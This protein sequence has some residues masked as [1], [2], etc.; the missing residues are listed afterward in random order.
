MK[1][2]AGNHEYR[3]RR[4][5]EPRSL[6]EAQETIRGAARIR[7]LGSRHSFND[8]ADTS[9]A[10]ITLAGLPRFL[11]IDPETSSVTVDGAIRY[12]ELCPALHEAGFAL[13]AMASLPHISIAG[14][15]ATASHGSGDR[16]SV[17]SAAVSAME[18]VRA[19]GEVVEL[20]REGDRDTFEG[21]V[22]GLGAL[23]VVTRLTLDVEPTF[24]VRQDVYERLP[25]AAFASHFD[26]ITA[27][28]ESVSFFTTWRD[29]AFDQVWLKRRVAR[30]GG[31]TTV[32][33]E[34]Y[35]APLATR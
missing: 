6:E 2:W 16:S 19:D 17:L 18:V 15:C 14:A 29:R 4:L 7:V 20:S 21:A 9:G 3:A 25:G 26:E 35:G 8:L 11:N 31:A 30:S 28:A 34:L 10:L 33:P 23:G 5:H 24:N 22:V 32:P 1:N 13:H 27:S 12:G